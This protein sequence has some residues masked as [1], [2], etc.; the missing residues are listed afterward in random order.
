[1]ALLL[2]SGSL[3]PNLWLVLRKL[4][5]SWLADTILRS[6]RPTRGFIMGDLIAFLSWPDFF[7][8]PTQSLPGVSAR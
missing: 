2:G 6:I 4:L 5:M 7:I 8:S 1:M 3:V